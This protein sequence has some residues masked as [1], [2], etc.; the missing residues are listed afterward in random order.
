MKTIGYQV[1]ETSNTDP[2]EQ[3]LALVHE[4]GFPKAG[5]LYWPG[6]GG[7]V[8][9]FPDRAAARA[10]IDR[11]AG[12]RKA[13]ADPDERRFPGEHWTLKIVPVKGV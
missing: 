7:A 11:T 10:A 3:P 2:I 13:F 9:L 12:M 4:P 6:S 1:H 8:T 5:V